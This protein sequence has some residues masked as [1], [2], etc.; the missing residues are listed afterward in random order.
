ML[1]AP[2][3]DRTDPAK[4]ED[5]AKVTDRLD[6]LLAHGAAAIASV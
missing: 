6:S 2:W 1:A 4:G 3:K 5:E